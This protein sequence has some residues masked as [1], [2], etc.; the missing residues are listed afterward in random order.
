[1]TSPAYIGRFAPSP[2]G[3]LH[4]GSL[5]AA[6]ASYLDARSHDGKWWLRIEDIDEPRSVAGADVAIL[7]TLSAHHLHWDGD[8]AYQSTQHGR[9][10][11]VV[12]GLIES[13]RAYFCQCTRKMIKAAG[14]AYQGTCRQRGL[15]AQG[16]AVRL[17]V[18]RPVTRFTDRIQGDVV[19]SDAHA[20]EDTIIKRRDGLYSYNLVVVLDD[21]HQGVTH[22]VRG[23][24]LLS[25]TS[26]HLTLYQALGIAAPEYAHF[27]VAAMLP[28]HKLSK[29]NHARA[30]DD[31]TP[32][33]NLKRVL[34]F[35]T[36]WTPECDTIDTC[37]ALITW[38][39]KHWNCKKLPKK[40][41]IIV[42]QH[43]RPYHY[44]P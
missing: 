25:T 31:R 28:G 41:E 44:E 7:R 26:A 32:L 14:G 42:D 22:I 37:E 30:I 13:Q 6:V 17:L 35:L 15:T 1:M 36:L 8:V 12:E 2:S 16:N 9:Y 23:F 27:P 4:F 10:Q 20:L 40:A 19:I 18:D 43:N 33:A 5:V 38:A 3:P 21:I 24:D 11:G 34:K 39:I 29:Q